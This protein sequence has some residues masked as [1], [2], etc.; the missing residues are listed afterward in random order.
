MR[1]QRTVTR[2][3]QSIGLFDLRAHKATDSGAPPDHAL[4]GRTFPPV[5]PERVSVCARR[6]FRAGDDAVFALLTLLNFVAIALCLVLCW[7]STVWKQAPLLCM[8]LISLSAGVIAIQQV[9]WW[10]L[11]WMKR[12]LEMPILRHRRVAVVTT[13]VPGSEPLEMLEATVQSLVGLHSPHD[14]WVLDEG[15]SETVSDLCRKY[16][17]KH[18]SRQGCT[19]YQA[20]HGAF[21][22]G[23]KFG[24]YNSWL[25]EVGFAN[26]DIVTAF[27]PD[28]VP[29][30]SFLTSVLGYFEDPQIAYVQ[31]AQAFG[32]QDQSWIARGAAEETYDYFSTIQ[33]ASYG[34]GF[35]IIVGG[36][37]THR[38]A[39]LRQIGGFAAHDADDILTT[40]HYRD[41]S[42]QG[43]YVPQILARGRTPSDCNAY[44]T[45]QR[46][47]A[48]SV[49]DIKLRTYPSLSK[50]APVVTRLLSVIHGL[51]YLG[52]G[53]LRVLSLALVCLFCATAKSAQEV[54]IQALLPLSILAA[55]YVLGELFRQRF[56]LDPRR[57]S[58][59]HWRAF[60]LRWLRWPQL[61]LALWD[62]ILNRRPAYA[63]TAKVT[64]AGLKW[65]FLW[66]HLLSVVMVSGCWWLG[67]LT[68]Q[69]TAL[70]H[71]IL[72]GVVAA[73]TVLL[74]RIGL[75]APAPS[76]KEPVLSPGAVGL[77]V[78]G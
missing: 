13:F 1:N 53:L 9:R 3:M 31:V 57:E 72:A 5:A 32:N 62:V 49:L 69:A 14:T 48:R 42:W 47:W 43:V 75:A 76:A 51:N 46:R 63:I 70:S 58:G 65:E 67:V 45:Q 21:C 36:H 40:L 78:Q 7:S 71:A 17:A 44:L 6:V 35:P 16:G 24:N 23:T 54:A 22:S 38:V 27:D 52:Q 59:L 74:T 56:Y 37:N 8:G 29:A 11:P 25:S 30:P 2:A 20:T 10:L 77:K 61:L 18:F 15:N 60:I 33:M 12:P 68:G 64:G 66:P 28:H 55:C 73:T 26:Y 19:R 39:A 41:A 50:R 34:M 4:D